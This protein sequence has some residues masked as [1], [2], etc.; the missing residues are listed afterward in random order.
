MRA[1][2]RSFPVGRARPVLE[3]AGRFTCSHGVDRATQRGARGR[4]VRHRFDDLD[5]RDHNTRAEHV[6]ERFVFRSVEAA[7]IY[8]VGCLR[9]DRD[10]L[11]AAE[12]TRR[13]ASQGRNEVAC[14]VELVDDI[15][16]LSAT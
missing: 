7:D 12:R 14:R 8:I 10:T 1:T 16:P 4:Q 5:V 9:V 15:D 11:H 13:G 3:F 2:F 6:D